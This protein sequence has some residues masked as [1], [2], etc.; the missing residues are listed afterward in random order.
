MV[1]HKP[2]ADKGY[3][4][5]TFSEIKKN[6]SENLYNNS[7]D[8]QS[9]EDK[10]SFEEIEIQYATYDDALSIECILKFQ[11]LQGCLVWM[12]CLY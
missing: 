5:D 2:A 12:P 9:V 4:E 3:Y 10:A 8:N 11:M 1:I 6:N 7:V